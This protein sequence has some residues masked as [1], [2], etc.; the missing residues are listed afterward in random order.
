MEQMFGHFFAWFGLPSVGLP[1]VFISA[2]ISATLIPIGSEPILFG[3]I[4]INP[5]LYWTAIFVAAIGNTG[6]GM[7][8]WW[9]GLISRDRKSVV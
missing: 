7:L 8:D 6:G 3:Y 9:L 2:F 4:S 5:H 1:A